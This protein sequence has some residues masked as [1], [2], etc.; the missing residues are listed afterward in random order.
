MDRELRVLHRPRN[1]HAPRILRHRVHRTANRGSPCAELVD[2]KLAA[3]RLDGYQYADMPDDRETW[4]SRSPASTKCAARHD[5]PLRQPRV[6]RP[7]IDRRGLREGR[8]DRRSFGRAQC[9]A[10]LGCLYADDPGGVLLTSLGVERNRL[11]W[12]GLSAWLHAPRTDEHPRA[13][14]DTGATNEDPVRDRCGR[15]RMIRHLL[16]GPSG[17]GQ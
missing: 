14:R 7:G 13:L 4:R 16:K 1:S 2:E 17:R 9:V 6:G 10:S 15:Q 11:R 3:G 8:L 5:V 12:S